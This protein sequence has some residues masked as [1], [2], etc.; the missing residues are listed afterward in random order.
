[1]KNNMPKF[2]VIVITYNQ[3]HLIGR[4]LDS[5]IIQKEFLHEI[6][7]SDDCSTDNNWNVI[8]E[9][10]KEFPDII[11]PFRQKKNVGIFENL[12]STYNN[13]EGNIIYHCAGDDVLC[14]ELLQN[15]YNFIIKNKLDCMNNAFVLYS[16]FKTISPNCKEKV[17]RN[18][19]I[20]KHDPISL[21]LR[22]L[23]FNRSNGI[24]RKVFENF[25]SVKNIGIFSDGLVD[26]QR[27]IYSNINY[28][29]PYTGSIYYSGIGIGSQTNKQA[30]I[31]SYL[32]LLDEYCETISNLKSKDLIWIEYQK[33]LFQFKK[34]NSFNNYIK[35]FK[36]YSFL[37][38][39]EFGFIFAFSEM[40]RIIILSLKLFLK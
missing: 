27:V 26:I 1:M 3:E 30:I 36:S 8:Q 19:L 32:N 37:N 7:V 33:S 2:S 18:N 9:Y 14:N 13:V 25:H 28:Y 21:K 39:L 10:K 15:A 6:I 40:K 34:H 31:D 24:S 23:I 22:N 20:T 35:L 4:A 17:F 12:I 5:I 38:E 16:D 29:I 11:K